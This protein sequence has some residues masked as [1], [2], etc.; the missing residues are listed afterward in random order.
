M[1]KYTYLTEVTGSK[2]LEFSRAQN[3]ISDQRLKT[4]PRYQ[5]AYDEAFKI[6]SS[7][8][9]LPGIQVKNGE[10]F[11]FWQ[12]DV[13]VKGLLRKTTPESF[14]SGQ[15]KWTTV[16]DIDLL[17]KTENKNWVYKGMNCLQPAEELCLIKLSDGGKDAVTSREFNLRKMSFVENGFLIPE[18]KSYGSWL[19][20]N[21]LLVGDATNPATLTTSGYPS[22]LKVL[23]RGERLENAKLIAEVPKSF[24]SVSGY[25]FIS[26]QKRYTL[27]N[28]NEAFYESD[29][30]IMDR[31]T[32]AIKKAAIPKSAYIIDVFRGQFL[33][34]YRKTEGSILGG[35][36]VSIPENE[37]TETS[38]SHQVIFQQSQTEF[39]SS[40]S[41]SRDHI[42]VEILK[43]VKSRL[44]ECSYHGQKWNKRNVQLADS[45]GNQYITAV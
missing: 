34:F 19:D 4:D 30:Y 5:R 27:V 32:F 12:D 18:S 28:R 44:V 16:L 35:S 26:D 43:D 9:K 11:N 21:T 10:I 39:F 23:K 41:V 31:N 17:A 37:I 36:L 3:Q 8:D 25:S 24:V 6:V 22:L 15:P 45:N 1:Q 14:N 40:L 29:T 13:N 7:K 33:V 20:E 2:A 42:Y 38:H